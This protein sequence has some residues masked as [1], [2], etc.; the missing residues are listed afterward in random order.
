MSGGRAGR[1]M[2][3]RWTCWGLV[4]GIAVAAAACDK[5]SLTAP[6]ESSITLFASRTA[7]PANGVAEITAS[8][9]ESAGTPVHNGTVVTFTTTVGTLDPV[10]ARTEDGKA[11]ARLMAMGQSGVAQVRAFSGGAA[12][13]AIEI[14]V[15]G[16]AVSRIVLS[17]SP[18]TV[19]SDG[20]TV[21]ITA[22]LLD[23][24][25]NRLDGVPVVFTT[26]AGQLD[27]TAVNS[28]PR[29]E[30]RTRLTTTEEAEV[31]ASAGGETASVTV[32]VSAGPLVSV[33]VVGNPTEGTPATF[34]VTVTPGPRAVRDVVISFGDG[35]SASLGATSGT[36]TV[37][38]LYEDTGTFLV[39]VTATDVS[40]QQT[41][42]SISVVVGSVQALNVSV[43][44]SAPSVNETTSF[45]ATVFPGDAEVRR[46]E[47]DFGD[48]STLTTTGGTTSHVYGGSG[49]VTVTV[50][51]LLTDGRTAVGRASIFVQP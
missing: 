28:G 9:I 45:T 37:S 42:V 51:V 14:A 34:N 44:A 17:A 3:N 29:G 30:A 40:G 36:A 7:I 21:T 27:R 11:S 5:M 16:G 50:T 1:P 6:T 18:G 47:W 26:S 49:P 48:G 4:L 22:V 10:E 13:E 31:T 32:A 38:H 2:G 33:A 23:E 25:G 35:A 20:G 41:E 12:A 8:V 15:G 39:T 24:H 43:T 19:P 46:Y